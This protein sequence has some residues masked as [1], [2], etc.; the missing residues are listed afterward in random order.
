MATSHPQSNGIY[1]YNQAKGLEKHAKNR[2]GGSLNN[3]EKRLIRNSDF[4]FRK[5][6]DE[7]VLVPIKQNV[8]DLNAIFTLNEIGAFIWEKLGNP[9]T[10]TELEEAILADYDADIQTVKRELEVFLHDMAEIG[11]INE[12]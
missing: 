7:M 3:E 4:I 10:L 11:A 9:I 1:F 8:A 6:V 12:V 2:S 5:I